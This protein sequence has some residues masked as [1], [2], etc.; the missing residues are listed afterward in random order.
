MVAINA[1]RQSIE[2]RI[3]DTGLKG[4]LLERID[5]L[6][7][8]LLEAQGQIDELRSRLAGSCHR[9]CRPV[10]PLYDYDPPV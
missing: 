4:E 9:G 6:Q 2:Q 7:R 5:E 3:T 10:E 8:W 1:L